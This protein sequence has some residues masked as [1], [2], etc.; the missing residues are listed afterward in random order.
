MRKREERVLVYCYRM[1]DPQPPPP[2]TQPLVVFAPA[3]FGT[4]DSTTWSILV[5]RAAFT[6][7]GLALSFTTGLI[8]VWGPRQEHRTDYVDDCQ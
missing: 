5:P 4:N 8:V 2:H 1:N 3:L 7:L 6:L